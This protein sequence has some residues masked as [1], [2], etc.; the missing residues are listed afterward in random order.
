MNIALLK[1]FCNYMQQMKTII[2]F[3]RK[4]DNLFVL[5]CENAQG[6]RSRICFDMTRSQSGIFMS[7]EEVISPKVFCAPFDTKLA[8]C[9]TKARIESISVDGENRILRF[10]LEQRS[11]IKAVFLA[12]M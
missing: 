6:A 12:C 8:Q 1:G 2:S 3:K 7:D 11:S 4:G 5:V 9:T 10:L